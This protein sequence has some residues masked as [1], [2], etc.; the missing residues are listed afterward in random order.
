MKI[1][2]L[3]HN[4]TNN[5][6]G[7]AYMLAEILSRKYD[8]EI[9]GPVEENGIW[10]PLRACGM[11]IKTVMECDFPA[12]F[13]Q[14]K[15]LTDMI[16]GDVIYAVKP[17]P[18]SFGIG[19]IK[20]FLT[21]KPLVLDIDDWE[22]AF[23]RPARSITK[24]LAYP[25]SA[26][27]SGI[28]K[29]SIGQADDITVVSEPLRTIY[30]SRGVIVPHG[31]NKDVFDPALFSMMEQKRKYSLEK[32]KLIIFAG[33]ALPHKGID[34]IIEAIKSLNDTS[35]KL[36][37]LSIKND[38][39]REFE[40]KYPNTLIHLGPVSFDSVPSIL[41]MAD[42]VVLPQKKEARALGQIP[43]KLIDAMAMARPIISTNISDI[44]KILEGCG[45]VVEPGDVKAIAR[46][47]RFLLDNPAKAEELGKAARIKFEKH[48]SY[49]TVGNVL[50]DIFDK[51]SNKK[52]MKR[53]LM[54]RRMPDKNK[55][56]SD[57]SMARLFL[58]RSWNTAKASFLKN[59]FRIEVKKP[60]MVYEEIHIIEE[61]LLNLR[62]KNCLEW[63]AGYSTL[64]F[65]KLLG[66]DAHW[67]SIEHE[68]SWAEKIIGLNQDQNVRVIYIA[69]NRSPWTDQFR[70]G[71]YTDLADYIEYPDKLG[72]LDFILIDGRAR[73]DCLIK[74][75]TLID[76]RGIVVLHDANRRYYHGP[77]SSYKYQALFNDKRKNEG[78]LWVGSKGRD[79]NEI[80]NVPKHKKLWRIYDN[81]EK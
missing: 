43:S 19:L 46:N 28:T 6:F 37:V 59:N 2:I 69:P 70:D 30:G 52:D 64:N 54:R 68:R 67:T 18:T 48:F 27:Y 71:A 61:I 53:P 7:R 34:L 38:L 49:E 63:G 9:L 81:W 56:L 11:D 17:H 14:A 55:Y 76:D 80:L 51:Y 75:L 4:L 35:I 31:R 79:I 42:L 13:G 15:R 32:F 8:I 66:K 72:K 62:P 47:I 1:S 29:R 36:V 16:S 33:T 5:G 26:F 65:S 58:S 24:L 3:A 25:N 78:G 21:K 74:A 57:R 44:P 10:E 41:S 20:K 50:Y 23:R 45:V 39:L 22:D 77:F 60:W 73:K 40:A 12:F